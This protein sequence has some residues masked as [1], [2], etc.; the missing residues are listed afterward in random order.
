MDLAAQFEALQK[1]VSEAASTVRAAA[2]ES[3]DQLKQRIDQA[4]VDADL[5]RKDARSRPVKLPT[6]HKAN[7]PR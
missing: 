4:Q 7:G 5:A 3:R 2:S 6:A 1:R